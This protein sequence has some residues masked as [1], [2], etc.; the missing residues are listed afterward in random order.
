MS[1]LS[2]KERIRSHSSL[3]SLLNDAPKSISVIIRLHDDF[4]NMMTDELFDDIQTY[5]ADLN[6]KLDVRS[7]INLA[8]LLY[9]TGKV[10]MN[11]FSRYRYL[12]PAYNI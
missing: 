10:C 4:K 6:S 5:M 11:I 9:A 12:Y 3:D 7:E 1:K 2:I 8:A